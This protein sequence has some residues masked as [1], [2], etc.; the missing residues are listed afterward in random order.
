MVM[1]WHMFQSTGH[2]PKE[3]WVEFNDLMSLDKD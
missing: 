1:S 3:S 2:E